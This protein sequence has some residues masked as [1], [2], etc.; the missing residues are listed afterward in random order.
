MNHGPVALFAYDDAIVERYPTIRAGVVNATGL[1]NGPRPP[2]LLDEYRTE[3]RA[4]S[5]RLEETA[6]SDPPCLSP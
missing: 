4:A 2:A 6:I 5:E 1:S 3:Q